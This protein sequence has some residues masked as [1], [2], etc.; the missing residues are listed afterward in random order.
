MDA[1]A[2]FE[3]TH[4]LINKL[5]GGALAGHLII[6]MQLNHKLLVGSVANRPF[7]EPAGPAF[8]LW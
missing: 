2:R 1:G 8:G 3:L 5:L 6:G 7:S 4:S